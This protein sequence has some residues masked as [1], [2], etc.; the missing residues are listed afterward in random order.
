M[1]TQYT[2]Q[3]HLHITP[4]ELQS[5]FDFLSSSG[6]RGAE[7][8]LVKS[9]DGFWVQTIAGRS[10]IVSSPGMMDATEVR[11]LISHS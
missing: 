10:S 5:F 3:S 11:T 7:V 6:L 1:N 2:R 8:A 9:V 4:H